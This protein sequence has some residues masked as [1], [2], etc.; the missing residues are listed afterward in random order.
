MKAKPGDTVRV[1]YTGTLEDGSTFDTSDGHDPIEFIVGSGRVIDGFDAAVDGL[2]P[3]ERARVTVPPEKAYGPHLPEL[4]QRVEAAAFDPE[5]FVGGEVTIVSEEGDPLP[6][7]IT[8]I[9]GDEVVLDFNHPLA[10]QALTFDVELVE[11]VDSL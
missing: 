2:E 9:E 3:G 5:P 10:G 6:A 1:H 11:V 7:R 8:A 4:V